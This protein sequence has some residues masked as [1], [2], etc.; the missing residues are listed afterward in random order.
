MGNHPEGVLKSKIKDLK[1]LCNIIFTS[2]FRHQ[3]DGWETIQ[4]IQTQ[5]TDVGQKHSHQLSAEDEI[6]SK[7]AR[8]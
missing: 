3:C 6:L 2:C 4:Q 5:V 7:T 8:L 1:S